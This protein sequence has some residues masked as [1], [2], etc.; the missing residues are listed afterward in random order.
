MP[1]KKKKVKV[2]KKGLF[3]SPSSLLLCVLTV[4]LVM[5]YYLSRC[6][7]RKR[8]NRNVQ[9]DASIEKETLIFQMRL[10]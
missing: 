7:E 10:P 9:C 3:P 6:D 4:P 2:K 5:I 1:K 8:R